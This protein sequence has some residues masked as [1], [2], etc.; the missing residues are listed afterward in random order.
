MVLEVVYGFSLVFQCSFMYF[1]IWEG[2]AWFLKE[3]SGCLILK[4]VFDMCLVNTKPPFSS[5]MV[6]S[7]GF[8]GATLALLEGLQ[9]E[10]KLKFTLV[11][12]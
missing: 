11:F 10:K 3:I 7:L 8:E 9:Q 5:F 1:S 2:F 12:A 4:L 6:E